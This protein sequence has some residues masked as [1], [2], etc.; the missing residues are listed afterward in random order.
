M[1]PVPMLLG[2]LL[3]LYLSEFLVWVRSDAWLF[4]RRGRGWEALTHG[5]L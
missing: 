2:C 4:R 3:L 5:G 1:S